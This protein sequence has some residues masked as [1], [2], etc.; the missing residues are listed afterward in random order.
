MTIH[1][2]ISEAEKA[3]TLEKIACMKA[4]LGDPTISREARSEIIN[5]MMVLQGKLIDPDIA[6]VTKYTIDMTDPYQTGVGESGCV[7]RVKFAYNP[8]GPSVFCGDV[9]RHI[10]EQLMNN[11]RYDDNILP[12]KI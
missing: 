5:S 11:P 10:W 4:S 2:A 6:Y 3:E 9:P 1:D 7:G 12:F 8:G